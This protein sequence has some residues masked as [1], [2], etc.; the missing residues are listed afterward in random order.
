MELEEGLARDLLPESLVDAWRE[1]EHGQSL[2]ARIVSA[3]DKLQMMIKVL[4]YQRQGRG[5]L[6]QFWNN[7]HNFR[8][9]GLALVERVYARLRARA[10]GPAS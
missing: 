10:L 7:P 1:A 6:K 4:A 3:A 8:T 2:E 5:D 9:M